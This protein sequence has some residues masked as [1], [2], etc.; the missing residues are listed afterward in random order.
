MLVKNIMQA[1]G[2]MTITV[3]ETTFKLMRV[4]QRHIRIGVEAPRHL[5]IDFGDAD[6]KAGEDG[7][8]PD[9]DEA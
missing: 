6:E 3:G 1:N 9:G 7:G 8:L 4:G 2:P 5:T